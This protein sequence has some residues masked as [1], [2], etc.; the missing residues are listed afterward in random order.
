V[1]ASKRCDESW[2][3]CRR[4]LGASLFVVL[5]TSPDSPGIVDRILS[6]AD[7][8]PARY[9]E[10]GD[11]IRPGEIVVARRCTRPPCWS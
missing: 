10:S 9:A 5:H 11:P 2:P 6:R 4:T 8:V 7:P 3:C 1:A